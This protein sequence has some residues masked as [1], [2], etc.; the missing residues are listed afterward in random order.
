MSSVSVVDQTS[1]ENTA[2]S[3]RAGI[4]ESCRNYFELSQNK[5][6]FIPGETYIPVTVKVLD[7]E[8]LV[9]LVDA[10]LD[11][12]LTAGRFSRDF[13]AKLSPLFGRKVSSLFVNSGSSA[14]LVAVSSLGAP[15]LR[16]LKLKPLEKGDEIITVAAG[17]P[18]TVNPIIQNGWTPVFVDVDLNTLNADLDAVQ[19]AVGP[20]TRAVI[21]AHTLGNAYRSDILSAWCEKQGLYLIEDCCD[22]LGATVGGRPV[23][24]FGEFATV[25]F[26]PAHHITTGEGGAVIAKDGRWKRVAESVRD[27]G[28]DCW[29]EPGKDNTCNKRFC[30][31]LGDL[32]EGYDH[33][34]TYSNIGYNLKATDMQAAIG[35]SQLNKLP[36][37][38]AKRREHWQKLFSGIQS[39][40]KLRER[41][42]P[43]SQT[44]G[45]EASWFGF[46]MHA[47]P[48]ID[49]EKLVQFLEE[50]KIGT[51]LLF[52]GNLTRQPAYKHVD[53]RVHGELENTDRIMKSTFWIGV[54][55]ALDDQR[56]TY[57]LEQLEAGVTRF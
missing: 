52:G 21:L 18:T 55:P 53:Y 8:D 32:P 16:D 57:M 34:Y 37:F 14:N 9:N 48:K 44:E 20:K 2:E 22:A 10:S 40:P 26:Y 30:W 36:G 39:S 1:D 24:S 31:K 13:E 29:C 50:K 27:W 38:V 17:F 49:R 12:W 3:A 25:S 28:R 15:M 56:I 4:L 11:L 5:K 6:K 47:D 19:A 35:L 33:K 42:R 23:G 51:R 54:H 46:A 45:T 43:V 41:L 7:A